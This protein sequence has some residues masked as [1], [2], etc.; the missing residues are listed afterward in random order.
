MRK[1]F[2]E[3]RARVVEA[4]IFGQKY[5]SLGQMLK[6]LDAGS[7]AGDDVDRYVV[8]LC[9]RQLCKQLSADFP[10]FWAVHRAQSVMIDE[11]IGSIAGRQRARL[12]ER[13]GVEMPAFLDWFDRWFLQRAT[14]QREVVLA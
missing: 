1:A 2:E 12:A 7:F 8:A 13:G 6:Q 14:P 9:S 3:K 11:Q 4:R 5:D 10:E